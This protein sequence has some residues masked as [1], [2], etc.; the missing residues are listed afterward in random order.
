MSRGISGTSGTGDRIIRTPKPRACRRRPGGSIACAGRRSRR[1]SFRKGLR[2]NKSATNYCVSQSSGCPTVTV[3]FA[4]QISRLVHR[5]GAILHRSVK[6][7]RRLGVDHVAYGLSV[8]ENHLI[9]I[10]CMLN[11][12]LTFACRLC[13]R[14]WASCSGH[15]RVGA[16]AGHSRRVSQLASLAYR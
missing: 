13:H 16:R 6:L 11:S 8:R 9:S 7:L 1:G 12:K 14:P 10:G 5:T 15:C 2:T 4:T 3:P